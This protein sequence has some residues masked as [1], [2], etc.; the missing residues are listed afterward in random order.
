MR[1][2]HVQGCRDLHPVPP[3]TNSAFKELATA[4]SRELLKSLFHREDKS[5][6]IGIINYIWSID[7]TTKMCN[8]IIAAFTNASAVIN[9][10][11][12]ILEHY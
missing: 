10:Y 4:L 7:Q 6:F 1:S 3:N 2:E 5:K 8:C 12:Q 9:N 11:M